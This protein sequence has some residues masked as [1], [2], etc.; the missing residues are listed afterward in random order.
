MLVSGAQKSDSVIPICVY[1]YLSVFF[2][3]FS[4]IDYY[5]ILNILIVVC[6]LQ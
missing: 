5:K 6:T 3:L 2:N 4:I 1:M